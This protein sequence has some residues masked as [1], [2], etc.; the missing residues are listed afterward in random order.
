M[1]KNLFILILVFTS[2]FHIPAET[3][4]L[5]DQDPD[6]LFDSSPTGDSSDISAEGQ[7]LPDTSVQENPAQKG[8]EEEPDLVKSV[9]KKTGISL[10]S[11]FAFFSGYSPGL[12]NFPW[13]DP[14][15][16]YS[17]FVLFG[18]SSS[19]SLD[20]RISPEL[21]V[22]QKFSMTFPELDF[23]VEEIFADYS[24]KDILY[25][26]MGRQRITWGFSPNFPFT[27][28]PA[29]IPDLYTV[30]GAEEI[31]SSTP[32]SFAFKV[33]LP[34]G[35]GGIEA[36]AFT[37]T[38]FWEGQDY[39]SVGE[40]GIG[41]KGNIALSWIDLTAGGFYLPELG[42]RAYYSFNTT[43][44]DN[45]QLYSEGLLSFD[46]P[47]L[48]SAFSSGFVET[49]FS[50][51]VL[52]ELFSG[53]LQLN[54]EYYYNGETEDLT[55]KN[56]TF[57][58]FEGHNLAFNLRLKTANKKVQFSSQ[59]KYNLTEDSGILIPTV[60]MDLLPNL[61]VVCALPCILGSDSGGYA[62][63]NPVTKDRPVSFVLSARLSGKIQQDVK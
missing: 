18:M 31:D 19:L 6:S 22:L 45:L 11:Q 55:L 63:E 9:L 21:R 30:P 56:T 4:D 28:L 35:I 2:L 16:T 15:W 59:L 61:T 33:N 50:A 37:R 41:G 10:D 38:G 3:D 20:Y 51:G 36:L 5:L 40:I 53:R 39:P 44:W 52:L 47:A 25:F 24:L 42:P 58:L 26:R 27:N 8:P 1:K 60:S 62:A 14:A 43:F 32:D 54:G 46:K 17:D 23:R 7:L 29:R 48:L 12:T 49:S 57:P 34:I 13:D